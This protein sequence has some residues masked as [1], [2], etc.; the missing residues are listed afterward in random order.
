MAKNS[1]TLGFCLLFTF[2]SLSIVGSTMLLDGIR[3]PL[4]LER[5]PLPAVDRDHF[6]PQEIRTE[7]ISI[8]A[9]ATYSTIQVTEVGKWYC[10]SWYGD[11]DYMEIRV[12]G[13]VSRGSSDG[14]LVW[15]AISTQI[16]IFIEDYS[17]SYGF[18][19][20]NSAG[21]QIFESEVNNLP[22]GYYGDWATP[23]T[24]DKFDPRN[25]K[26]H[27]IEMEEVFTIDAQNPQLYVYGH[28]SFSYMDPYAMSFG[29]MVVDDV[30]D[31]VVFYNRFVLSSSYVEE[32]FGLKAVSLTSGTYR[33]YVEAS[34][35]FTVKSFIKSG[36][37]LNKIENWAI[38]LGIIGAI[39]GIPIA[40]I[41]ISGRK[42]KNKT[43]SVS[44]INHQYPSSQNSTQHPLFNVQTQSPGNYVKTCQFCGH[45]AVPNQKFCDNCGN[46]M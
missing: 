36:M 9:D 21:F 35:R 15:Q 40:L 33:I 34:S 10:I 11:R 44:P 2:V 26:R 3:N 5:S 6:M 8:P 16:D 38:P 42:K 14:D 22:D 7:D 37:V 45:V 41:K 31:D 12:G 30:S 17:G 19:F 29:I 39:I 25:M 28:I 4:N 1:K 27:L 23:A 24:Y 46:P 43:N 32:E 13:A 20:P 18:W